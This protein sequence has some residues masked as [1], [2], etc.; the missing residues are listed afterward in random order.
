MSGPFEFV[1]SRLPGRG[2]PSS[3]RDD[4]SPICGE[5]FSVERLEEHARSLAANQQVH[6]G[7]AAG[8]SLVARL[9]A[10]ERVLLEAYRTITATAGDGRLVAPAAEWLL[11]NFHL[12]EQQVREVRTDLPEGY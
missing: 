8:R 10:N 7:R 5:L 2:R 4:E 11:D 9:R 1:L 12:V 3:R 6:A